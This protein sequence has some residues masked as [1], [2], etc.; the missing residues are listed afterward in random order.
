MRVKRAIILAA[1]RGERLRPLTMETPKPLIEVN[2]V[3]MIESVISALHQNSISEIYV[4]IGYLK[5]QFCYLP[6]KYP[7]LLLIENPQFADTNNISSLY[8]ARNHLEDCFV[9]DGDQIIC[10]PDALNP[11]FSISGYDVTWCD[12]DTKEWLLEVEDG[13][14]KSCSRTG[15]SH[16]WQLYSISRW[17]AEEGRRLAG[18]VAREFESGNRDIYWDDV[19]LFCYPEEYSLGVYEIKP[20]A[21]KEIDSLEELAAVDHY[22]GEIR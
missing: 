20:G 18:H 22:Y 5:E 16:G 21:V 12:G 2:G 17:S 19:V 6:K 11:E 3:R 1:G 4:V 10:D 15:G 14:I 8:Y 9:L 7:G 13:V